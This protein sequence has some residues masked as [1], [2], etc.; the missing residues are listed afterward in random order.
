MELA[1][2]TTSTGS[3]RHSH[4]LHHILAVG[5]NN[6][7]ALL[8]LNK[9]VAFLTSVLWNSVNESRCVGVEWSRQTVCVTL[10]LPLLISLHR[11]AH[12]SPPIPRA[13]RPPPDKPPASWWL[14][15]TR[16]YCVLSAGGGCIVCG[17]GYIMGG[18]SGWLGCV[19]NRTNDCQTNT[20]FNTQPT[21]LGLRARPLFWYYQS[22]CF[23]T[24]YMRFRTELF[25]LELHFTPDPTKQGGLW[26]KHGVW[27]WR[28]P[29]VWVWAKH[30]CCLSVWAL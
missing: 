20:L 12:Y 15:C 22:S 28:D 19:S 6:P 2:A 10:L 11:L 1:T 4:R 24:L 8:T 5:G 21:G 30:T 29:D 26:E 23:D 27:P 3:P 7:R 18:W 9:F 17:R 16:G 25:V 13:G 14:R